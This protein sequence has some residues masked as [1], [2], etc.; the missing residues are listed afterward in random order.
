MRL[1]FTFFIFSVLVSPVFAQD[2][3]L[4]QYY[5]SNLSL[6]PAYTGNYDGDIR[7]TS[8]YRSQWGQI[9]APYK[10]NMFSFEKKIPKYPDEIGVGAIFINDQLSSQ[11]LH[12]NKVLLSAAYQKNIKGNLIRAGLQSGIVFRSLNYGKQTFPEQWDYSSGDYNTAISSGEGSMNNTWVYPDIGLGLGWTRMLKGIKLTGGYG[13]FHVTR[14]RDGL[15]FRNER[16]SMRHVI[17]AAAVWYLP[18]DM[19]LIPHFLYMTSAR[20]TDFILGTRGTKML[21]ED[22][23]ILLGAGYRGS[24]VNSDAIMG[25]AGFMWKRF[26]FGFSM[27]FNI[28]KL[29][30]DAARNKSAW[31]VSLVYTTPALFHGKSTIPCDRY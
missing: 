23:G 24:M 28:S 21:N 10:T 27:D 1:I 13:L 25:T 7:L 4:T 2:V 17:N 6:N 11:Y 5:T 15:L 12:T 3:H 18:G 30:W 20:A 8:N 14:P 29:S 16:L 9:S 26:E 31:E 22:F 19:Q